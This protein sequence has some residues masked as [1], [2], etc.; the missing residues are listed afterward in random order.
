MKGEET[1]HDFRWSWLQ[2]VLAYGAEGNRHLQI[3]GQVRHALLFSTHRC[4]AADLHCLQHTASCWYG[5]HTVLYLI[6]ACHAHAMSCGLVTTRLLK[7]LWWS[8]SF[9]LLAQN[10]AGVLSAREF[11]WWYNG[12]PDYAKLQLDLSQISSVAI[13]G[14]GN[15]AVDCARILLQPPDRLAT[16][17]IAQHALQQLRH[18]SVREVHLIGRRGPVQV[19]HG[20]HHCMSLLQR[21]SAAEWPIKYMSESSSMD[22]AFVLHQL[23]CGMAAQLACNQHACLVCI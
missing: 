21:C 9:M 20:T 5:H 3:P 22:I 19:Q 6:C 14:L 17:D 23:C 7:Q 13:C 18:S 10:L 15:V 8:V 16:T 4:A 1:V 11:V 2:V 12:H